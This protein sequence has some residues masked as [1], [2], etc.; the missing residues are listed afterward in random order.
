[1][2]RAKR[3]I[4]PGFGTGF[5]NLIKSVCIGAVE[6]M[7]PVKNRRFSGHK[8]VKLPEESGNEKEASREKR[9]NGQAG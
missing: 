3:C 4:M 2:A 6:Y 1:M 8:S 7:P 5:I 9:R